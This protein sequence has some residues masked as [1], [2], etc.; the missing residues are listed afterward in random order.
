MLTAQANEE[1]LLAKL[2]YYLTLGGVAENWRPVGNLPLYS[3][4]LK[5]MNRARDNTV[6]NLSIKGILPDLKQ[7]LST[8]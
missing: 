2:K 7:Q 6:S 8:I 4:R 5:P 1:I 3:T